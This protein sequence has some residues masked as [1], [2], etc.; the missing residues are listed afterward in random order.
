M[1]PRFCILTLL[2]IVAVGSISPQ[3][4]TPSAPGPCSQERT[5]WVAQALQK[6]ETVKPGM[7]RTELLKILTTEG[8]LSTRHHQTFV[9]RDCPYFKVD[10]EF[11]VVGEPDLDAEDGQDIIVSVSKPYLQFSILD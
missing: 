5:A 1:F 6:M 7:T 9:S 3:K 10:V 4:S 8:G 2:S 11:R